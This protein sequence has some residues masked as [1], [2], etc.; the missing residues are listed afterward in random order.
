MILFTLIS[1]V[2]ATHTNVMLPLTTVSNNGQLN[3]SVTNSFAALKSAGVHGVMVDV[4][5]GICETTPKSYNFTGYV[6]L[7]D[8]CNKHGL[9]LQCVMSFHQCGGNVGDDCNIPIPSWVRSVSNAWYRDI[10]GNEVKEYVSLAV[11]KDSILSGR[12][13]IQAYKDFMTAFKNAMG[14]RMGSV[15]DEIQVGLGP[16]GELRYPGYQ[17]DKWTFPGIGAFQCF[18]DKLKANF[19]AAAKAAGHPEW[20]SPPTDAGGYNSNPDSTTFF[21]TNGGYA[22]AYGK[23]F[24]NWYSNLLIEH[25]R[26]ILREAVNIFKSSGTAVAMKVAG[27][28]WWYN[29][30]SHA[31]EM[32]TG[33][34]NGNAITGQNFYA[35][36]ASLCKELGV[37]LDFTCFEMTNNEQPSSA[38][39]NPQGLVSQVLS[40]AKSAGCKVAAEN[41]LPRYDATA[42]N[43][44]IDNA[45]NKG[46]K[47]EALTYL[48]LTSQLVNNTANFNEFK[49]L[50]STLSR[51]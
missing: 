22:S 37:I 25:G 49:R 35:R 14:S 27:I 23:F 44:I 43:R 34:V 3:E 18:S 36:A 30:A 12:T 26:N 47:V 11:D 48:R 50:V 2:F 7:A 39:S 28:H 51:C 46:T 41:A 5:W 45:C 20:D 16:A 19:K 1:A 32:T 6:K 40:A 29:H 21:R 38:S 13:P 15:V 42:Y 10:N 17:L 8:I 31:A 33:Y 24:M 4:W 9:K